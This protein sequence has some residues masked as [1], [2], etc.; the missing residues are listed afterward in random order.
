MSFHQL[1]QEIISVYNTLISQKVL[2]DDENPNYIV[3]SIVF[4]NDLKNVNNFVAGKVSYQEI[5]RFLK[6]LLDVVGLVFATEG[7]LQPIKLGDTKLIG[8]KK[9]LMGIYKG[10]D[11]NIDQN[12]CAT[13]F[14]GWIKSK[15]SSLKIG[16]D[17]RNTVPKS[18]KV[19]DFLLEHD[20]NQA[21][22]ECKRIHSTK[23]DKNLIESIKEKSYYWRD[24]AISQFESTEKSLNSNNFC[25]HLILDISDYGKNCKNNFGDYYTVGLSESEEIKQ[26]ID[27]LKSYGSSKIDEITICWSVLYVFEGKPRAFVYRTVPLKINRHTSGLFNYEGWTIEFYPL[28]KETNEF[29]ELRISSIA[30]TDAWIKASWHSCI[31][32]LITWGHEETL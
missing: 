15:K 16:K 10:D 5:Y 25:R 22:I 20:G 2:S 9:D 19:C 8:R 4:L 14:Q 21:L 27:G 3:D 23:E 18:M 32:N 28:G 24:K 6:L 26:V 29:R 11:S 13:L 30:R 7:S 12:M 1:I 31:D 17:L